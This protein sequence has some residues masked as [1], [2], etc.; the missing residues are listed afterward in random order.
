M[1]AMI[2]EI[3]SFIIPQIQLIHLNDSF[4]ELL[5]A[6]TVF[7]S[8]RINPGPKLYSWIIKIGFLLLIPLCDW[9]SHSE[10]Q[11]DYITPC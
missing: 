6:F 10:E 4:S 7:S 11:Y 3:F 5:L 2:I 9:N 8:H 1:A